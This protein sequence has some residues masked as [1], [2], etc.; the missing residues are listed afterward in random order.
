[1]VVTVEMIRDEAIVEAGG[2][3]RGEDEEAGV[4]EVETDDQADESATYVETRD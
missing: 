1:V 3:A 2:E 4:V